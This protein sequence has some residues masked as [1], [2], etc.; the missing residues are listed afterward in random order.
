[1]FEPQ[2][3]IHV[4]HFLFFVIPRGLQIVLQTGNMTTYPDACAKATASFSVLSETIKSI[5]ELLESQR[6]R[7]DLSKFITQLQ[8]YEKEKL[9]LTA[10]CHLERIRERNQKVES[11]QDPRTAKLLRDG[12]QSLQQKIQAVVEQI[13][14]VLDEIRCVVLEEG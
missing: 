5:Q 14:E 13:N 12:V 1:M 6:Q 9:Y 11:E 3:S 8:R 10:A 2:I 4:I 7:K